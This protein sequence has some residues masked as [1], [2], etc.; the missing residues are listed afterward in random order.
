[1]ARAIVRCSL[2]NDSGS[3]AR[4]L[5]VEKLEESGFRRIGTFA[6]EVRGADTAEVL[7]KLGRVM[8]LLAN[9]PGSGKLDHLWIYLDQPD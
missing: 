9:P 6:Y 7:R 5:I 2:N 1:M 8:T 3:T 4:N